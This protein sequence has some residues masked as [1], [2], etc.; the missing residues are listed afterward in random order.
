[1]TTAFDTEED[2][3]EIPGK[4]KP[5]W[6]RRAINGFALVSKSASGKWLWRAVP[7]DKDTSEEASGTAITF[8][9]AKSKADLAMDNF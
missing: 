6:R 5:M 4:P 9:A 1:M 2:Y 3:T 7:Y 8:G